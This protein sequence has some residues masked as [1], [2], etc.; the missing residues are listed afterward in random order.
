M[1]DIKPHRGIRRPIT[2][3]TL[4]A[5]TWTVTDMDTLALIM[6]PT[7]DRTMVGIGPSVST[8]I[9]GLAF[10]DVVTSAI[11]DV[12]ANY[13]VSTKTLSLACTRFDSGRFGSRCVS[14]GSFMKRGPLEVT[15]IL[16]RT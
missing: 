8:G 1:D 7:M 4:V 15:A 16:S 3:H 13:D 10:T 11:T 5:C 6:R 14:C 2:L 12:F 9:A